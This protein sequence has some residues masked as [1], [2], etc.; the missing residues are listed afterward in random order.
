MKL[1]TISYDVE[2]DEH[3][4]STGKGVPNPSFNLR[5]R[6]RHARCAALRSSLPGRSDPRFHNTGLEA[7]KVVCTE[8]YGL[9][10]H[11]DP[12]QI[13]GAG[14]MKDTPACSESVEDLQKK[15]AGLRERSRLLDEEIEQLKAEGC[16]VEELPWHM[17]QLH[18]YNQIKDIAHQ[19]IGSL[20]VLEG[21][22]I[23]DKQ[24]HYGLPTTEPNAGDA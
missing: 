7:A 24:E 22:T 15:L 13:Q 11:T 20:A 12:Q 19:L 17:E 5:V 10:G 3:Q 8:Q 6:L 21:V 16:T 23:K 4:T 9:L 18:I 2:L 14:E 1:N